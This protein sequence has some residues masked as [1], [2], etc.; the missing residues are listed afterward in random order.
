MQ[1]CINR[2][3]RAQITIGANDLLHSELSICADDQWLTIAWHH[4]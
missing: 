1:I 4:S 3:A 2:P